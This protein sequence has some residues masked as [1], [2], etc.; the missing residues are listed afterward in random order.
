MWIL[1]ARAPR[2]DA[3]VWPGRRW[4]AAL[5]AVVWPVM[6]LLALKEVPGNGGLARPALCALVV[7][8]SLPRLRKAIWSN[9]RYRFT[10]WWVV[11]TVTVLLLLGLALKFA[12]H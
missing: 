4:L 9:H 12:L 7:L 6:L 1:F 11:R 10:T 3:I 8:A 2:P 5:D